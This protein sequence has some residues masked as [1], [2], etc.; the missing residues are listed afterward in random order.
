MSKVLKCDNMT[1]NSTCGDNVTHIDNK[2]FIYCIKCGTRRK[3]SVPTRKLT[4]SELDSL[5]N[6]KAL[7][8]Y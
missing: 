6:G 8:K 7:K 3:L 5:I 1:G 2:G 4:K